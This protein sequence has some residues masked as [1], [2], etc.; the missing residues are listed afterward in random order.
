MSK[1]M[2]EQAILSEDGFNAFPFLDQRTQRTA[3]RSSDS[4][5]HEILSSLKDEIFFKEGFSY[6]KNDASFCE[7]LVNRKGD[8]LDFSLLYLFLLKS[9]RINSNIVSARGH[10]LIKFNKF[11]EVL[12]PTQG[13]LEDSRIYIAERNISEKSIAQGIYLSDLNDKDIFAI[14]LNKKTN[15]LTKSGD[16]E[17]SLKILFRALSFS[18]RIP[19]VFYNI[20]KV[21]KNSGETRRATNYFLKTVELDPNFHEAYN[22]LGLCYLSANEMINARNFFIK[23][24]YLGNGPAKINLK[25]LNEHEAEIAGY[26]KRVC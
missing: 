6:E 21:L 14:Y 25:K 19:E 24:S 12:E 23:A 15:P 10:T 7:F 18:K 2:L 22:C 11:D 8:C 16:F 20:G 9:E 17:K 3:R 5:A 26:E 4:P 13:T 1:S